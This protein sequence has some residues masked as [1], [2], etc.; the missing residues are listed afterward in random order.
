M[1]Y[2]WK[3][4]SDFLK[5]G[6]TVNELKELV[7]LHLPKVSDNIVDGWSRDRISME[8]ITYFRKHYLEEIEGVELVDYFL[9]Q[10]KEKNETI[11]NQY[12]SKNVVPPLPSP[13]EST[14]S[15]DTKKEKTVFIS[16]NHKDQAIAFKI[17]ERLEKAGIKVIIDAEAMKTGESIS[18]F[19]KNCI[20][21]SNIT[22]SLVS[23]NSL[24]SAWVAMETIYTMVDVDLRN[25]YF[26]PCTIDKDFFDLSFRR[27]ALTTIDTRINNLN[28]EIKFSLENNWG[29]EDLQDERTRNQKLRA[30]LP[31][32]IG[33]LKNSLC[34]DLS[35]S[36][37]ENGIEKVIKDIL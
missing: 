33:Q 37:F 29:I 14:D 21:D 3:N 19:I 32:I 23:T 16:Y 27:T 12:F 1:N 8:I 6:L 30:E 2:N 11:Y 18:Q 5:N 24:L 17:K 9:E 22:L 34:V 13:L 25:K 7:L 15:D 20:K 35:E 26:V 36:N 10:A 28:E 4:I 31:T